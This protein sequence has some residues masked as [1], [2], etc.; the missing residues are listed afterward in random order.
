MKIKTLLSAFAAVALMGQGCLGF[1]RPQPTPAPAPMPPVEE[2]TPEPETP[3]TISAMWA[4]PNGLVVSDQLPGSAVIVSAVIIEQDGWIVIHAEENG[5][6]GKIIGS[7]Y[8]AAGERSQVSVP[9]SEATVD[10]QGYY[11]MLH[12]D[13][14]GSEFNPA[15]DVP[16]QSQLGGPIMTRFMADA[17]ATDAPVVSP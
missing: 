16:V 7:V 4:E 11:A 2:P 14:G 6:A 12:T 17:T 9:L 8:I 10:G 3:P 1:G 5:A 15:E 13:A